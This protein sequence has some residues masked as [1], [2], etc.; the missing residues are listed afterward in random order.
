MATTVTRESIEVLRQRLS[1]EGKSKN[2]QRGY[3]GDA[4][5]FF[6]WLGSDTLPI[7]DFQSKAAEHLNY[8]KFIDKKKS[9]TARRV[10]GLRGFAWYAHNIPT[11]LP[12][13]ATP[14][15]APGI[16]HPLAEGMDGVQ[17][18]LEAARNAE[19]KALVALTGLCGARVSEARELSIHEIDIQNRLVMLG[20][21]RDKWRWVPMGK[22]AMGYILT[23]MVLAQN[24]GRQ[25]LFAMSDS[26]ARRWLHQIHDEAGLQGDGASHDLRMTY[27]TDVYDRTKD[28]RL[29]QELLGH[30]SPI[31]TQN[32]IAIELEKKRSAVEFDLTV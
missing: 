7:E 15:P 23:W 5:T 25:T 1:E 19:E 24:M 4:H 26:T 14:K 29:V 18:M 16:P 30:S 21:K 17:R 10:S 2:T 28:I 11:F 32:Y 8:C 27:G 6:D 12:R 13:Y 31:T 22:D 20:G 3:T 9:T